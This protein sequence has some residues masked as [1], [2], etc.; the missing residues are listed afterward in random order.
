MK[1]LQSLQESKIEENCTLLK[2]MA[3]PARI[4]IITL[5][6]K[7]KSLNVSELVKNLQIPQPTVSQHL[8]KMKGHVL[9]SNRKGLEVY[10]YI[11]NNQAIRIIEALVSTNEKR[12]L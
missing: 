4:Q 8:M 12:Y 9:G 1:N 11:N 3:H 10:Y 5:L 6:M 7:H 2:V